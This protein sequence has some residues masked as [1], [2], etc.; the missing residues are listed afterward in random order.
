MA[1]DQATK[2]TGYSVWC[3][4]KLVKHGV[5]NIEDIKENPERTK[6]TK[7]FLKAMVETYNIDMVILEDIQQQSNPKTYKILAELLG[8]LC[9]FL[10]EVQLPYFIIKPSEWRKILKIGGRK[11]REQKEA[12]KQLITGLYSVEVTE[13]EADAMAIGLAIHTKGVN[14]FAWIKED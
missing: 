11:R 7:M 6:N 1:L 14:S 12:T 4:G 2:L 9:N 5:F 13:D 3:D 10:Y 8:V